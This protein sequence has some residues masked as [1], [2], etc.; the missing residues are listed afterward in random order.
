MSGQ[1][2][3]GR[4]AV[5]IGIATETGRG[6]ASALLAAG[7]RVAASAGEP[8]ALDA[9][10]TE[11]APS[12]G[13]AFEPLLGDADNPALADWTVGEYRPEAV[14]LV[15]SADEY[16]AGQETFLWCRE[17]IMGLLVNSTTIVVSNHAAVKDLVDDA[18]RRSG[19][20]ERFGIRFLFQDDSGAVEETV[21]GVMATVAS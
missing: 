3:T 5:V 14:V 13:D 16:T 17:V 9:A 1:T 11:F 19:Q 7:Y 10:R 15:A 2:D 20:L 21:A 4:T 18:A 6:I 12:Y 8:A